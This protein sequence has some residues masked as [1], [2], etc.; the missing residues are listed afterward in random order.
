MGRLFSTPVDVGGRYVRELT[1][2]PVQLPT[3]SSAT[4]LTHTL[5]A[6]RRRWPFPRGVGASRQGA[7]GANG[8]SKGRPWRES[9]LSTMV[10]KNL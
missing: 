10:L 1:R 8:R 3:R 4:S 7:P 5:E 6:A 9:D 2:I